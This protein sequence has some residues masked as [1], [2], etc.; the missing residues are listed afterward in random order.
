MAKDEFQE[1]VNI[2][3]VLR[4]G[5]GCP[6]DRKQKIK[7][8]KNYILEETYELCDAVDRGKPDLVKEELG[9]LFLLLVFFSALYKEKNKFELKDVLEGINS[10]LVAR[11]PHVFSSKKARS[12]KAVLDLWIKSKSREKKRKTVYERIP[13]SSP[14]L[15]SLYLFIKESRYLG[16]VS[17][18]EIHSRLSKSISLYKAQGK[19]RDLTDLVFYSACLI[20]FS[21]NP[22]LLL[23]KKVKAQASQ[24]LYE[25][26]K[27]KNSK[28]R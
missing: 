2:V 6:W 14:A 10:K 1:L 8:L 28:N 12:V 16:S 26:A 15:F 25:H 19:S 27:P 3:R 23:K 22:E 9:D 18:Q 7:D 5:K 11:H 13:L 24:V 20:S 4:S 21:N 17:S